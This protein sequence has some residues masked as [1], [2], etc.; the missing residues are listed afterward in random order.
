M[1]D[2]GST[3][4]DLRDAADDGAWCQLLHPVKRV[5]LGIEDDAPVRIKIQGVDSMGFEKT[6]AKTAAL[7][8]NEPGQRGQMSEKRLLVL[9]EQ[10]AKYQARELAEITI[11]WENIDWDGAVFPFSKENAVKM[12]ARY[13]W[14]REQLIEFI[15]ERANYAKNDSTPS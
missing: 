14:I 3:E 8:A 1:V 11:G 12:F 15:A 5:E 6:I 13:K 2:F 10:A 4:F 9:T 7:R